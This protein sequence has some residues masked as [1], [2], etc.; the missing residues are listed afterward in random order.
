M[1]LF[2]DSANLNEIEDGIRKGA[3]SGV[4]TNPSILAKEPK[5][6]FIAH[7][8][9]IAELCKAST[10]A[11]PL[12]VEVFTADPEKMITQALDIREKVP[13]EHLNIKIPIGWQE[14]R[15]ISALSAKG[16]K[17][18]CTAI[19]TEAQSC[20]AANAGAAY[21]SIFMGRLRDVGGDPSV[22]IANTR[23]M[24]DLAKS[25][26]EIIVGSVRHCRDITDAHLAGAHIVTAGSKL[27][28]EMAPHPQT[29]KSVDG[30]LKDF[31]KWLS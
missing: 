8:R 2:L 15:A 20:L 4:T 27:L 13:Y 23:R 11:L 17:V 16:I 31:E 10:R 29:A 9:K 7:I 28:Q 22:V 3:I 18:N 24:L 1:K 30:F 6:D 14:L 21:V 12:S 25:P 26:A 5:T 19:F